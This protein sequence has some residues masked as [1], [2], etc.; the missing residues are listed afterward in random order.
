MPLGLPFHP[1]IP[2][3]HSG[4]TPPT[5]LP[6]CC[7][8]LAPPM[9]RLPSPCALTPPGLRART[10]CLPNLLEPAFC[11]LTFTAPLPVAMQQTT[12]AQVLWMS[13]ARLLTPPLPLLSFVHAGST[14]PHLLAHLC[15]ALVHAPCSV[16][17]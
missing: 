14:F 2:H 9:C 5:L 8:V 12:P 13:M 7:L 3:L 11:S 10:T 17:P 1:R 6:P 15:C 16:P 4:H